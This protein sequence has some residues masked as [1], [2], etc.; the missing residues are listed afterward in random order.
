MPGFPMK[1]REFVKSVAGTTAFLAMPGR[2]VALA[3]QAAAPASGLPDR[4]APIIPG[5]PARSPTA[6][7]GARSSGSTSRRS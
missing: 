2:L 1:R 3:P 7:T 4:Y 6:A 5:F